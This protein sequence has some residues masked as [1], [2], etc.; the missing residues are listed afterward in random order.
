ML[1]TKPSTCSDIEKEPMPSFL[2]VLNIYQTEYLFEPEEDEFL[3]DDDLSHS[4][5]G[6]CITEGSNTGRHLTGFGG[7]DTG[8]SKHE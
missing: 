7:G 8:R 1:S 6:G 4:S 5:V 3:L 2:K